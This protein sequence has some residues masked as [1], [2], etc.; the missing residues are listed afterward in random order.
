MAGRYKVT[1]KQADFG[2][3]IEIS[4]FDR[5]NPQRGFVL[6][7]PE[8]SLD[9]IEE[10]LQAILDKIVESRE[11]DDGKNIIE[12]L[13]ESFEEGFAEARGEIDRPT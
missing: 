1:A 10:M 2:R 5:T 6:R 7:I 13:Q 12:R 9:D 11:K 4:V 8:R 3:E